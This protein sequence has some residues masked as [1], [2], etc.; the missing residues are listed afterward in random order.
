MFNSSKYNKPTVARGNSTLQV[1]DVTWDIHTFK[2]PTI[3][4]SSATAH[5]SIK[6]R[7]YRATLEGIAASNQA[8]TLTKLNVLSSRFEF[9]HLIHE[10]DG[11][12]IRLYNNTTGTV[13]NDP[14]TFQ[15]SRPALRDE[16]GKEIGMPAANAVNVPNNVCRN[17]RFY[18]FQ[19]IINPTAAYA[20]PEEIRNKVT[21]D[22]IHLNVAVAIPSVQINDEDHPQY[23]H[24]S[25][26]EELTVDVL[27]DTRQTLLALTQFQNGVPPVIGLLTKPAGQFF[28]SLQH[29]LFR[30]EFMEF[31]H[32]CRF[33][34]FRELLRSEFLG[35]ALVETAYVVKELQDMKQSRY[36]IQTK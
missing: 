34:V 32:V 9:P 10:I 27:R 8:P 20:G 25:I 16:V 2:L 15:L 26:P 1:E 17:T 28:I 29:T 24:E 19:L 33:K 22:T 11:S 7:Y 35:K 21:L 13:T 36:D 18:S 3:L 12:L 14:L 23:G 4:P 31:F 30:K 6:D 5:P